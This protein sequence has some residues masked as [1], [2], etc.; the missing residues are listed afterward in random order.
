MS[1]QAPSRNPLLVAL[2]DALA[3]ALGSVVAVLAFYP[4]DIAKT[5]AQALYGEYVNVRSM[6]RSSGPLF[7]TV[8]I[9]GCPESSGLARCLMTV[10]WFRAPRRGHGAALR[11]AAMQSE[12][13]VLL[14]NEHVEKHHLRLHS[15]KSLNVEPDSYVNS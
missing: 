9:R 13:L 3:G 8:L 12:F 7:S 6:L 4:I 1:P 10:E 2:A 5:R 15:L 14:S 11:T